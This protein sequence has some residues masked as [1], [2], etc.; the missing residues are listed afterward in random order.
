M[1]RY[2]LT[3]S[4]SL[5]IDA[6]KQ[7]N[8]LIAGARGS[9]KTYGALILITEL[10]SFPRLNSDE[11]LGIGELPTQIYIVDFKNSDLARLG[12][13]LPS[14]RVATNKEEAIKVVSDYDEKMHKRLA[15][16]KNREF[17]ATAGTLGMPMFYLIIDEWSATNAAFSQGIT[18]EDKNLRYKWNALITDIAMLNR[19]PGF[20]LGI[21]SQQISVLNS[22]LN[23]SIQE[24][25][26]MK[27]HF[28]AANMSLYRLT[29]GNDIQI[30]EMS[31][32]TGEAYAWIEGL[33]SS[34]YV[35]PFGM[36]EIEPSRLWNY[37]KVSLSNQDDDKFLYKTTN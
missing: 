9:G 29:F 5:A 6:Y 28:G 1:H 30:P 19:I 7:I 2:T 13:L 22:G 35:I 34:G 15:F 17:G 8:F 16:I 32:E 14:G 11:L 27:L 23:S 4:K 12:E 31:L 10:A 37:L 33:T 24:E 18:K 36:P 25:A 21:L 20:G 26:G 3:L